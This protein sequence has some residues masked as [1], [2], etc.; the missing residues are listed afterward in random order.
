MPLG[1]VKL[2]AVKAA[3]TLQDRAHCLPY[4]LLTPITPLFISAPKT[5]TSKQFRY[6]PVSLTNGFLNTQKEM[7]IVMGAVL[8]NWNNRAL[9]PLLLGVPFIL[10]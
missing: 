3:N 1:F 10:P 6:S 2:A 5:Q 8:L 7:P 4:V 9:Q